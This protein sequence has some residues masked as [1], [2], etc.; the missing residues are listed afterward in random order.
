MADGPTLRPKSTGQQRLCSQSIITTRLQYRNN[1]KNNNI[2]DDDI[3]YDGSS[4]SNNDACPK[5]QLFYLLIAQEID[6]SIFRWQKKD[7]CITR[8]A[9]TCRT[10]TSVDKITAH[11]HRH[12]YNS[13]TT[14][15][16]NSIRSSH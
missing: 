1:E 15:C 11:H 7:D 2:A 10:T 14:A 8:I 12:T 6:K 16:A 13:H 4:S 3:N 5:Q 9:N